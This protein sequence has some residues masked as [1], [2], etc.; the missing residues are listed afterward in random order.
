MPAELAIAMATGGWL[1]REITI[2]NRYCV[3][4]W[5]GKCLESCSSPWDTW[6]V[7]VAVKPVPVLSCRFFYCVSFFVTARKCTWNAS[8]TLGTWKEM[9]NHSEVRFV[10]QCQ[11][12]T[13]VTGFYS[14][15]Q[16]DNGKLTTGCKRTINDILIYFNMF[17]MKCYFFSYLR[18]KL[19]SCTILHQINKLVLK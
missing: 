9:F 10:Q 13:L 3:R 12:C 4:P 2:R 1:T 18:W 16:S 5:L 8:G 15:K 7:H 6:G 17:I 19:L 11:A 14:I